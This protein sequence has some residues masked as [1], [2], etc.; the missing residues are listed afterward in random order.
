M[1]LPFYFIYFYFVCIFVIPSDANAQRFP[2][3]MW[4][5]GYL[6]LISEDTLSG[7]IKYDFDNDA[8]QIRNTESIQTYSARKL[9]FFEI[10]DVTI[11]RYR[12]FYSL[13]YE[14]RENFRAPMLFEV[15]QEGDLT[16]LAREEIV[17]D[18]LNN[19]FYG[20]GFYGGGMRNPYMMGTRL[21]LNFD[22]YFLTPDDRLEKYFQKKRG[23]LY[24]MR[25]YESEIKQFMRKNR[26]R[27]DR[28]EHLV[29]ITAYYN[30]LREN[31]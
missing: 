16:L 2:S 22:Y 5:E 14:I 8:V 9:L 27:H 7:H 20:P 11:N 26:L 19:N 4:H 18:N 31:S 30:G 23:L 15:L 3:E 25:D 29:R 6:V 21:R 28:L 1:R 13:P 17:Q 24:F 12:Y 10:F